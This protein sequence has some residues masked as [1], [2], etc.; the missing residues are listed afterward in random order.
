M[1]ADLRAAFAFLTVLPVGY[2][3]DRKPGYSFAYFPVVGLAIG[4]VLWMVGQATFSSTEVRSFILLLVWVVLTGALHLD[5]FA[6]ACDALLATT[7][8]EQRL[9][10]M[11]DPHAGTWAVA[12]LIMLLLGKWV[13]LRDAI[14]PV[15][16]ATPIVAR[17]AMVIAAKHFPYA[18]ASGLG[19]YFREGL[20]RTQLL[21]A[22]VF[23]LL[24][25]IP[26]SWLNQPFLPILLIVS[27]LT[28]L[29]CGTWAAR[30]LGGG[31]TGD[32][33]GAICELAELLCL[34]VAAVYIH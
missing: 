27:I 20:G 16:L 7:T 21:T 10:I 12:G 15:L 28:V 13:L 31:L 6:D 9:A 22:T 30:R 19:A 33:Y 14:G 25:V 4:A 2:P 1:L 32:V 26:L 29:A 3:E 8:P 18:R 23:T 17:W 34:A 24:I 5:G 11:K